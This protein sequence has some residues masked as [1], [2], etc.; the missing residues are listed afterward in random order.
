MH[1][2]NEIGVEQAPHMQVLESG[3]LRINFVEP[4]DIGIYECIARNEM[5]EIKSQPVRMLVS[6]ADN[7]LD[8]HVAQQAWDAVDA[9]PAAPTFIRKPVDQIVA[10]HGSGHVLLDCVARG[11]PQPDI[12]WFV[13]GRQL[14][15][16]TSALQ[17]QS[18]G[19]L[20]LLEPSQLTAGTY[21]CEAHNRLG[22]VQAT[23]HIEV[24]GE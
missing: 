10:L 23:A 5:G 18:N 4:N 7:S 22:S 11:W 15:Q 9:T 6:Q 20:V 1:G 2:T 19:S 3:A 16:S 14:A 8:S 12:Q 21:R 17:L 24:K 13:N